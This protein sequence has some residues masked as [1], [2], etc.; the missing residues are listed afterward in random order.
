MDTIERAA[1]KFLED[2]DWNRLR[3]SDL[4]KSVSIEA[5]ELLELFQWTNHELDA[6]RRDTAKIADIK[7]ELADVFL[8]CFYMSILL[9]FDTETIIL[10]KLRDASK[11]YPPS[12]VK[13]RGGKEPGTDAHYG[14]IKKAHRKRRSD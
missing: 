2:R 12:A 8:Y 10:D 3:P 13:D 6:V 4:A 1:K 11:K 14:L 5:N 9:G 7:K